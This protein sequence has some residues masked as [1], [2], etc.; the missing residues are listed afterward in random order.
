MNHK[1][2]LLGMPGIVAALLI[3]CGARKTTDNKQRLSIKEIYRIG[4]E[5]ATRKEQEVYE[6]GSMYNNNCDFDSQGRL[7]VLDVMKKCVRVLDPAGKF[8]AQYFSKGEGPRELSTP[9]G[10]AVNRFRGTLFILQQFGF[11]GKEFSLEGL[12]LKTFGLP[13]QFHNQFAFLNR[14]EYIHFSL[15]PGNLSRFNVQISNL[16]TKK[17]RLD[18][19]F[20]QMD[21]S[22]AY[23]SS[24]LIRQD[25]VYGFSIDKGELIKIDPGTGQVESYPFG[26]PIKQPQLI[27][28]G[29]WRGYF[30]YQYAQPCSIDDSI[31]LIL[32]EQEFEDTTN[33]NSIKSPKSIRHSLYLLGKK[34]F[35]LFGAIPPANDFEFAKVQYGNRLLF[36]RYHPYS[37]ILCLEISRGG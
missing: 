13:E 9:I 24:I 7:Y 30:A 15:N 26:H 36:T 5:E 10:L 27:Q 1:L 25:A 37:Q 2:I 6:F 18:L 31:G 20:S 23:F 34:G 12:P 22:F 4:V 16:E 28:I 32:S 3:G 8:V 14:D 29:N 21:D 33:L 11:S 35:E 19:S 17:N